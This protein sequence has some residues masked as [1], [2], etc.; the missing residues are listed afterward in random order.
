MAYQCPACLELSNKLAFINL[1]ENLL[2]S[3]C[4]FL[5]CDDIDNNNDKHNRLKRFIQNNPF[6]KKKKDIEG[7]I[8]KAGMNYIGGTDRRIYNLGNMDYYIL[9]K[10]L[11]EPSQLDILKD[12]YEN[13]FNNH[14][15]NEHL[16]TDIVEKCFSYKRVGYSHRALFQEILFRLI[17]TLYET[18]VNEVDKEFIKHILNQL[19]TFDHCK[20]KFEIHVDRKYEEYLNEEYHRKQ[21]RLKYELKDKIKIKVISNPLKFINEK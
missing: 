4:S 9:V 16:N 18:K 15:L 2:K 3:V 8:S 1:P 13:I 7:I 17:T 19:K 6:P 11:K 14:C 21:E 5:T 12:L 20:Y 10:F